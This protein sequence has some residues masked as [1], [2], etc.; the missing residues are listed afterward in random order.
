MH[1]KMTYV[2]RNAK[3]LTDIQ[4]NMTGYTYPG[5]AP[6]LGSHN[7]NTDENR[8][9]N[10]CGNKEICQQN[11][12]N[13]TQQSSGTQTVQK[14]DA[15]TMTDPLQIDFRLTSEYLARCSSTLGLPYVFKYEDNSNNSSHNFQNVRPKLEF[16]VEPQHING[17]LVYHCPECAYRFDNRDALHE[18]LEDHRQRP[19][20]CDICGASLKRKEHL[21]RHKQGHNKDRPYQCSMCCKAFKRNEHLARHM[22][23]HSGSKNQIC[24]ECGKAFYRK[25]H[26]K[27]HLQSHSGTRNKSNSSNSQNNQN[28][29]NSN[30]EG[31]S[32]FA[33]M[34]R[35]A[36]PPPF[37]ILRT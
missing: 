8:N 12:Q 26:L 17:M 5:H 33:M 10:S 22:I 28:A 27:K 2:P 24:T 13:D 20:I 15:A 9:E 37:S 4:S 35:Q 14:V 1:M 32:N 7:Q 11:N 23:I 36:G 25:D 3:Y 29:Q 30:E 19:H 31:L 6:P 34:M 21:D 18:H 16:E